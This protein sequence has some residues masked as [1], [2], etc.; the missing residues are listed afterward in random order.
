ME[1]AERYQWNYNRP[2]QRGQGAHSYVW[3]MAKLGKE[4]GYSEDRIFNDVRHVLDNRVS[5][6]EIDQAIGT[7]KNHTGT[8]RPAAPPIVKDGAATL[9]RIIAQGTISDEADL[10]ECSP[11]RLWEAP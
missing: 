4:S 8:P 7:A 2:R 10:W 1:A 9:L 3:L 5:N 11:I 6:K